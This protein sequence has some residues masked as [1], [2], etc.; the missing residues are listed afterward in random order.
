MLRQFAGTFF[1]ISMS[2]RNLSMTVALASRVTI[3]GAAG[4]VGQALAMF[5]K[6]NTRVS[7][8]GLYDLEDTKGLAADL[9]HIDTYSAVHTFAGKDQLRKSLMCSKILVIA[10]GAVRTDIKASR[11]SLFE[12]NVGIVGEIVM[13]AAE[14]CPDAM[15]VII[16]NPVNSFVPLT[17]EILKSKN[18]YDPKRLFGMS[19]LD[20]VR[21]SVFVGDALMRNPQ[22]T[23]IPVIGGHS[24]STIVPV[25]SGIEPPLDMEEE[26]KKEIYNRIVKGGEAVL[27]A[28]KGKGTCQLAVAYAAKMLCDALLA[29][30]ENAPASGTALVPSE[31]T[32]SPYFSSSFELNAKGIKKLLKLPE[33]DADE[34]LYLEQC[35]RTLDKEIQKGVEQAKKII[36]AE[37]KKSKKE[38]GKEDC[39]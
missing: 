11:D 19:F 14:V 33:L 4:G 17:A 39:N 5:V 24:R 30:L 6:T 18:V 22:K 27:E 15:F 3:A 37:A 29:G 32:K 23:K 10:A 34:K 35:M 1:N 38:S 12:K 31:L 36:D 13:E 21:A 7:D 25:L 20:S 16:T 26:L 2:K 9:S 8:L 28:K